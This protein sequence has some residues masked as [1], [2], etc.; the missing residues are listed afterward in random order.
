[1]CNHFVTVLSF[2]YWNIPV[3]DY[4]TNVFIGSI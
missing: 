4:L 1:M 2:F 3:K